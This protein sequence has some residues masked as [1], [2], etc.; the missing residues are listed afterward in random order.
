[1]DMDKNQK[2]A[3]KKFATPKV[4]TADL[5]LSAAPVQAIEN[6]ADLEE[7][8]RL[9]WQARHTV[10]KTLVEHC[11]AK[12]GKYVSPTHVQSMLD[13]MDMCQAAADFMTRGS[14]LHTSVCAAAANVA[15]AC[16][17]SCE[18]LQPN[19]AKADGEM[20]RCA[21]TCR[22]CA[23]ACRDMAQQGAAIEDMHIDRPPTLAE[24]FPSV[25]GQ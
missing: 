22:A 17:D 2:S 8:I 15:D 14:P 19:D 9:C 12:G 3:P 13:C 4:R 18:S 23:I 7:C 11:L 5:H 24:E 16:A 25:P 20:Q 6:S 1:M 10:Q 21:D